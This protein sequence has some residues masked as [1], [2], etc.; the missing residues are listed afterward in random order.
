MTEYFDTILQG[1][2]SE[3]NISEDMLMKLPVFID[4]VLI[5]GIVD[6][7]ECCMRAGEELDYEDIEDAANALINNK[8]YAGFFE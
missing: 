8:L 1:Y 5:E 2:E 6:A 4:M 7:F 3:T